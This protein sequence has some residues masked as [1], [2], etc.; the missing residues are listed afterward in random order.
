MTDLSATT[1]HL[2]EKL[3][4]EEG[5]YGVI[6]VS[7][8]LA[9][10][11]VSEASAI[12]T[13]VLTA[14]T[15]LVFWAAHV[16]A[17]TVARHGKLSNGAVVGLRRAF[18]Q[19]VTHARGF[20]VST[21]LPGLVLIAGAFGLIEDALALWIGLWVNVGVLGFLGYVSY[22]RKSAPFS[23]RVFGAVATASF[24]LLIVIVKAIVTH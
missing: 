10:A 9:V 3:S 20:L 14:V 6:L 8:L 17:G 13:L 22:R 4:T 21:I 23:M 12:H 15:I 1:R 7:G 2:H 19:S 5:V 18:R 11:G 24:G 16:Y